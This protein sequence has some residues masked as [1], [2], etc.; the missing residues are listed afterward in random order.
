MF[1]IND[2]CIKL[3]ARPTDWR[4]HQM[5]AS[6]QELLKVY[7]TSREGDWIRAGGPEFD[8]WYDKLFIS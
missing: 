2:A 8:S 7:G 5:Q 4:I 3:S 1:T 6:A